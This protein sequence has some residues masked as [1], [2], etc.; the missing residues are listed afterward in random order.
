MSIDF[1]ITAAVL[2]IN[3]VLLVLCREQNNSQLCLLQTV[4]LQIWSNLL[5]LFSHN[6]QMNSWYVAKSVFCEVSVTSPFDDQS[7]PNEG[8][9]Q[10]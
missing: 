5:G 10:I 7:S 4:K 2:Q 6:Y 3:V 9:C 8:M 1:Y